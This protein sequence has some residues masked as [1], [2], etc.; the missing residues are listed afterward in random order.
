MKKIKFIFVLAIIVLMPAV[1]MAATWM[2]PT[3][4]APGGNTEP[5]I[6]VGSNIEGTGQYKSGTL[7]AF[8]ICL[9]RANGEKITPCL[10]APSG[11]VNTFP[12]VQTGADI[13]NTNSG[14]VIVDPKPIRTDRATVMPWW[15]ATWTSP[16]YDTSETKPAVKVGGSV[17]ANG[18]C[19]KDVCY[20]SW[21]ELRTLL[22]VVIGNNTGP[23][24]VPVAITGRGEANRITKFTDVG[25]VGTSTL[26]EI[27]V[28]GI[29]KYIKN[30]V[31]IDARGGF[32]IEKRTI[33][34]A[35][36]EEGRM[37]LCTDAGPTFCDGI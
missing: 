14:T 13:Y 22:T 19:L 11:A 34:P 35:N 9:H 4:E 12:W 10:G 5:P 1:S 29:A 16:A 23:N 17:Q 30:D 26:S 18:F 2:A 6:N 25:T 33:D 20:G 31:P 36:A 27:M 37:W 3:A 28:G 15:T 7:G 24:N 21:P 32:I 8:E